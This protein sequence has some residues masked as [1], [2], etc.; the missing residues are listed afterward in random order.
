MAPKYEKVLAALKTALPESARGGYSNEHNTVWLQCQV[1]NFVLNEADIKMLA[2]LGA[3]LEITHIDCECDISY[4][5]WDTEDE[6]P[7]IARVQGA[8]QVCV[9][10]SLGLRESEPRKVGPYTCK[11]RETAPGSWCF[12]VR[13]NDGTWRGTPYRATSEAAVWAHLDDLTVSWSALARAE[14]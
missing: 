3:R 11:V 14:R 4:R 2:S 7:Q 6:H 5:S 13:Q 1:E 12:L 9:S 8:V 10:V